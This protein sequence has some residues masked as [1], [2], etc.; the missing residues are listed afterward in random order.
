MTGAIYSF[1]SAANNVMSLQPCFQLFEQLLQ[2]LLARILL[3]PTN[4]QSFGLV[5]L[6]DHVNMHVVDHLMSHPSIVLQ[7]VVLLCSRGSGDLSSN[8]QKLAQRVV[9]YVGQFSAVMLGNDQLDEFRLSM[10][11][12]GLHRL[13]QTA[14]PRLN[15]LISRNANVFS[16]SRSFIEGISPCKRISRAGCS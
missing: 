14:C 16:V 11:Q 15:G 7:D 8:G 4:T 5:W 1:V 10:G 9:R 3:R 6:W 12:H 13:E 2:T